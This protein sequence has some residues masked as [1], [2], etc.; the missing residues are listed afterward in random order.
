M[1]SGVGAETNG[2]L[3]QEQEPN[4]KTK[5]S[6]GSIGQKKL[7]KCWRIFFLKLLCGFGKDGV[8]YKEMEN[9][10]KCF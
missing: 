2:P 5:Q 8:K 9:T 6:F 10:A 4:I 3:R 7:Q 1:R